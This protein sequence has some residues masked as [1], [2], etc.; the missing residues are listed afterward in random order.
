MTWVNRTISLAL[1]GVCAILWPIA[2]RFPE[3]A[4]KFPQVVLAAVAILAALIFMRTLFPSIELR[5]EAEGDPRPQA[6][7]VPLLAAAAT[8]LTIYAMRFAGFFPAM[9]GLAVALYFIL[10]VRRGK[11][12]FA[13]YLGALIFVYVVFEILLGVPLTQTRLFR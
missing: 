3:S 7:I 11:V 8:G 13:C 2:G 1:L 12:Y 5:D 4:A 10:G 9:V 6:L